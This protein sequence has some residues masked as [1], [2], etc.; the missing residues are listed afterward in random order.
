MPSGLDPVYSI[1]AFNIGNE[2]ISA[3]SIVLTDGTESVLIK[4]KNNF[5]E[6]KRNNNADNDEFKKILNT[7]STI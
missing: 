4:S 6:I 3:V 7:F 1:N 2:Q 5:I